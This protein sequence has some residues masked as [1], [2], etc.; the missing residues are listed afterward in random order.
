[1]PV[2]G[3]RSTNHVSFTVSDLARTLAFYVEGLGF[4]VLSKGP[5][6][7]KAIEQVTGVAGADILVAFV[8]APGIRLE[9]IEYL[10]PED[11]GSVKPRPCDVG[12]AHVAFNVRDFDA[13]LD[14]AARHSVLRVGEPALIDRGPNKGRRVVYLRDLDGITIEFIEELGNSAGGEGA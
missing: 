1:M 6:D 12:F 3:I 10:A 9:L 2:V 14:I 8:Q 7:P 13:A 11:R 5:R 4:T